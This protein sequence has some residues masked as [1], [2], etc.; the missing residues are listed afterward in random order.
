MIRQT[1]LASSKSTLRSTLIHQRGLS[2]SAV[3]M[4]AGDTGGVR[5]GGEAA[6]DSFS[7]REKANEDYYVKQKE[8]E[9]LMALKEKLSQQRKHLDELD[10]HI[11]ELTKDQGGEHN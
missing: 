6:G 11:D 2:I 4:A 9:K 10:K 5:S 3:R 1:L 7:K 8:K